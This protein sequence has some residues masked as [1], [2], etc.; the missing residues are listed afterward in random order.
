MVFLITIFNDTIKR[1][2][3]TPGTHLS[4][5]ETASKTWLNSHLG[6]I[7]TD[8]LAWK[9]VLLGQ[10]NQYQ[11]DTRKLSQ[12][13]DVTLYNSGVWDITIQFTHWQTSH[14]DI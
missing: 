7:Y 11:H 4:G 13:Q 5:S 10:W 9:L 2:L 12:A 1:A 3:T 14:E 6:L 8:F